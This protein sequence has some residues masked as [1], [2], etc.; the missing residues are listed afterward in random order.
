MVRGSWLVARKATSAPV[1]HELPGCENAFFV[2]AATRR[3]DDRPS[4]RLSLPEQEGEGEMRSRMGVL[5]AL[6]VVGASM[7][8]RSQGPSLEGAWRV[9]EVVV[10]GAECVNQQD[11][12]TRVVYLY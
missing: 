7:I 1:S 9:T 3:R 11:S 2:A 4:E 10:T 6:L 8:G 12:A 5:V